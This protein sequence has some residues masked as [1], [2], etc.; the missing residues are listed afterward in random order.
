MKIG[1]AGIGKMG[2]AIG[3]RLLGLGHEVHAWNRSTEKTSALA[4][5]GAKIHANPQALSQ[6][7]DLVLSLLT[8]E[9]AIES[10]YLGENGL[11]SADCNGKTF[12]EMST[13]RPAFQAG[14]AAKVQARGA[15]YLEC[16]V[17]GS[18]G[19]AKDGKLIGFVGGHAQDLESVRGVLSQMCRI[20]EH[21]GPHGAGA[22]MK[23]AV[24]LPL[25]VYW[26]TLGEALSIIDGLAVDPKR[27]VEILSESSGGPNMLKVRGGM[28][29]NAM[30]NLPNE[31]IT[32]NLATMRKDVKA[33][34]EQGELNGRSMPLTEATLQHFERAA[35]LGL[36]AADCSAYPV[37]WTK[38]GNKP[39][40]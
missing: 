32:V 9:A 29:A 1:I 10:V 40:A 13:V 16:P 5:A 27:V 25:M 14:F 4:Q 28:I 37:W 12:I 33:M 3:L 26:Q 17:S 36:D 24:N 38:D 6:A 23:L 8:N 31:T 2:Q 21:I 19:P 15:H 34:L 20:V 7:C 35:S 18:I 11:L 39:T 30:A 22:K